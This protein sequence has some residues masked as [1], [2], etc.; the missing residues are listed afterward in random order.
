MD[1]G[2]SVLTI[3]QVS[4]IGDQVICDYLL[5]NKS[6]LLYVN[7][8]FIGLVAEH[9]EAE[10]GWLLA[11]RDN[12]LV[13]MLPFLSKSGPLGIA[14]NS[15]AYYGSNGG[16]IQHQVDIEAKLALVDAFYNQAAVNKACSAT[17]ITNPL[18]QD[19][20]LYNQHIDFD[21][22]DERIGQITHLNGVTSEEELL[23]LF[24]NPRPRN[25]RRAIKE[26]VMVE[27]NYSQDAIDFLF[28]THEQNLQA[29]G[30]LPKDRSF[31]DQ[32]ERHMHLNDWAI[33][34]AK[35]NNKPIAALLLFY[36]NH[37][38]E[39]FTPATVE[40]FRSSQP[41]SLII[42][43]SMLDAIDRGFKNWNW[44][45]TWLSQG[46]VYDFKKRWGT[47]DYPYFYFTKIF[48]PLL[49]SQN[50][51]FLLEYY[52]GFYLIPFSQLEIKKG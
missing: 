19:A 4:G 16:V 52:K 36:F 18:E 3:D 48:N 8:C 45:G 22:R 10:P 23:K 25:I 12:E 31:F 21:F 38:V 30:G 39:Y 24:E 35:L 26:G 37:T 6:S 11:R 2:L 33:F 46:G 29:I 7:P 13:G 34:T 49:E 15:L 20:D 41:L 40:A 17:L 14:Y 32:I 43:R 1:G 42:F 47:Q 27:K 5:R 51:E 50:R 28:K 9:L 44:G